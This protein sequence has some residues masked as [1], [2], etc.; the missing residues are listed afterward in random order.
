MTSLWQNQRNDT[1]QTSSAQIR[2]GQASIDM[3][4]SRQAVDKEGT[5]R[6]IDGVR[7]SVVRKRADLNAD[8]RIYLLAVER[9]DI[10]T[11]AQCLCHAKVVIG[12]GTNVYSQI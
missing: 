2:T 1:M 12:V 3:G 5:R 8:E 7:K 10:V 4:G 9:G 11:V 6:V